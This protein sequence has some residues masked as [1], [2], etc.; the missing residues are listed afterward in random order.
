M[1]R[2][3]CLA[4][5]LQVLCA[6]YGAHGITT[7]ENEAPR[8]A[9]HSL[10]RNLERQSKHI[11]GPEVI[12]EGFP[13]SLPWD[14]T[15][16]GTAEVVD[17]TLPS[18]HRKGDLATTTEYHIEA[19]SSHE[20]Q[21]R[22]VQDYDHGHSVPPA[23]SLAVTIQAATLLPTSTITPINSRQ[24]TIILTTT[25]PTTIELTIT[26]TTTMTPTTPETTTSEVTT[27][28][29][30]TE[31]TTNRTTT[32]PTTSK[33]KTT[34]LTAI[35]TTT[36]SPT[37]ITTSTPTLAKMRAA[38]APSP[39]TT[40]ASYGSGFDGEQIIHRQQLPRRCPVTPTEN[41]IKKRK[42]KSVLHLTDV[43]DITE[44]NNKVFSTS[45]AS[46]DKLS[47]G[48][49][50][51]DA[52][53][54]PEGAENPITEEDEKEE[55]LVKATIQQLKAL[56]QGKHRNETTRKHKENDA[57]LSNHLRFMTFTNLDKI[58]KM[59]KKKKTT[60]PP[61]ASTTTLA[62]TMP[63]I[64][65]GVRPTPDM[66]SRENM[67]SSNEESFPE[68]AS[69]SDNDT[70]F[71]TL[72]F[73]KEVKMEA[74]RLP[75][76]HELPTTPELKQEIN[77][78]QS[79]EKPSDG[80]LYLETRKYLEGM[81]EMTR[82]FSSDSTT[83]A[84]KLPKVHELPTTPELKREIN[85]NQ[86]SEKPS[87]RDLYLETRKYLEGVRE[88][89]R[90]HLLGINN[91]PAPENT[92]TTTPST[93]TT[94]AST[95]A[96][97]GATYPTIDT[98]LAAYPMMHAMYPLP[99]SISQDPLQFTPNVSNIT[100][101]TTVFNTPPSLAASSSTNITSPSL[102]RSST[103]I[104]TSPS[105]LLA[106]TKSTNSTTSTTE[107]F[108]AY[109]VHAVYPLL[110]TLDTSDTTANT[111]PN[112]PP[113]LAAAS[114]INTTISKVS[115]VSG[116]NNKATTSLPSSSPPPLEI[117]TTVSL[118]SASL[119]S[120][121]TSPASS[122]PPQPKVITTVS[123]TSASEKPSLAMNTTASGINTTTPPSPSPYPSPSLP[124][125]APDTWPVI[126][127]T[128]STQTRMTNDTA[129]VHTYTSNIT[130]TTDNIAAITNSSVKHTSTLSTNTTTNFTTSRSKT[131]TAVPV[132]TISI[133]TPSLTAAAVNPTVITAH[134]SL[135]E[136]TSI[137]HKD[138]STST[139]LLLGIS[140][141]GVVVLIVGGIVL[142]VTHRKRR[143]L[144]GRALTPGRYTPRNWHQNV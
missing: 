8:S 140:L 113:A 67:K 16:N 3:R 5:A 52:A 66:D 54:S 49:Y 99:T 62:T 41:A 65:Q 21:I 144:Q 83:S 136:A 12:T 26:E 81:R 33:M 24:T 69:R 51:K 53:L 70:Y 102:A 82:N 122:S 68:N 104:T 98:S 17:I 72:K 60:E 141:I 4:V 73:L 15:P 47:E 87:D 114:S 34:V 77:L 116:S 71:S 93:T 46:N 25:E 80:D 1:V 44:H 106:T 86:S 75:E 9:T 124:P 123:L 29:L 23:T 74:T 57:H 127:T 43:E 79:S 138:M 84:P 27:T 115:S 91:N 94:T 6:V 109:S 39:T 143:A 130:T 142:Y 135:K 11:S 95:R 126:S 100:T 13:Q 110:L 55:E 107:M 133:T 2:V 14:V 92:I 90:N 40:S 132:S 108:A 31:T 117:I 37:A 137:I 129:P 19:E 118:T 119:V 128:W 111:T 30:Q 76:V 134:A 88:R 63:Q 7:N 42:K 59:G 89:T 131:T 125:P 64:I 45:P 103:N 32:E 120:E 38:S 96:S 139:V 101:N 48:R 36:A 56:I 18:S 105:P 50:V 58:R 22:K 28:S 35:E 112:T 10:S 121:G 61:T 97:T 78:N 20:D 85:L